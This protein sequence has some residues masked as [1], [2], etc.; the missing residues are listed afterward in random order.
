MKDHQLFHAREFHTGLIPG[1]L[2][3]VH[4]AR[5]PLHVVSS[6]VVPP[7][8]CMITVWSRALAAGCKISA[9]GLA[10]APRNH[11]DLAKMEEKGGYISLETPPGCL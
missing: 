9:Q 6:R 5:Y 10:E 11:S 4:F 1:W 7:P 8:V 2:G 3:N